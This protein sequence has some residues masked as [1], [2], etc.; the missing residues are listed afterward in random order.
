MKLNRYYTTYKPA[1]YIKFL[2][3]IRV[4]ERNIISYNT[5]SSIVEKS[6]VFIKCESFVIE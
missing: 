5:W 4:I 6:I 2:Y 1:N 3:A